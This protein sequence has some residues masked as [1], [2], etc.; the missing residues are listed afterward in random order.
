MTTYWLILVGGVALVGVFGGLAYVALYWTRKSA[1]EGAGAEVQIAIGRKATEVSDAIA[2][3]A[4][5]HG[6]DDDFAD[7]LHKHTW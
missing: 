5:Q 7:R 1:S 3:A 2:Q 6:S 4:A